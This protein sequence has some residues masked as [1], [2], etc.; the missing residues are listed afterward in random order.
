MRVIIDI[1]CL[2][3]T[4]TEFIIKEIAFCKIDDYDGFPHTFLIKPPCKWEELCYKAKKENNWLEGLFHGLKW[5]SGFINYNDIQSIFNLLHKSDEPVLVYV[6]GKK[7]TL[8]LK[9]YI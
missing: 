6:K 9:K 8:L 1:Q 2:K 4:S 3:R 5:S 7:I